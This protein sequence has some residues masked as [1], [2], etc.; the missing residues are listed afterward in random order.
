MRLGQPALRDP[1]LC[2]S[3]GQKPLLVLL[4][5]HLDAGGWVAL[6]IGIHSQLPSDVWPTVA[7]PMWTSSV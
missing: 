3:S 2:Y 5:S 4:G 6:D 1:V 7:F